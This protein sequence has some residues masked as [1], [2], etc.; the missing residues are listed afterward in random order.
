MSIA[1]IDPQLSWPQQTMY[2]T[3]YDI[4]S[5]HYYIPKII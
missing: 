5:L 2:I 4:T 3:P 1:N